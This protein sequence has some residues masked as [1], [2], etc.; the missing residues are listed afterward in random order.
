MIP[1]VDSGKTIEVVY[2]C[3]F[4]YRIL[5]LFLL[6][7]LANIVISKKMG[8]KINKHI[9]FINV[10][11]LLWYC[12]MEFKT[13]TRFETRYEKI[14]GMDDEVRIIWPLIYGVLSYLIILF[15]YIVIK[16]L[17]KKGGK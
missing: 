17:V 2:D 8:R 14:I 3:L 15:I 6:V 9:L 11:S 5:V 10:F 16:K 7:L 13:K 12:F 4:D 1:E